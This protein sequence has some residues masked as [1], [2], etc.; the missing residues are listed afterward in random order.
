MPSRPTLIAS[1]QRALHLLDTV[2]ASSRPMTAKALARAT[3]EALPTTYHLL[4]TLVHEGYLCR[5]DGGYV[6]GDRLAGLSGAQRRQSLRQRIWP[7]LRGLRD[8]LGAAA[9]LATYQGGEVRLVEVADSAAAPRVDLWVDLDVAGHATA[10]G[11]AVLAGLDDGPR[12]EY[13]YRHE[14]PDLTRYTLTDRTL[15]LRRLADR[16]A[17]AVDRQEY[18]LG[19][20]CVAV[21]LRAGVTVAAV[22]VSVPTPRLPGLLQQVRELDRAA[23]LA[24]LELSR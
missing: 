19:T 3:G 1:V 4:R 18:A 10:L 15:L 13:L 12:R 23:G 5:L 24:A 14:L 7:V 17:L 11:K 21:G 22:A 6:L 2:G 8:E 16:P 9:Y 20:A